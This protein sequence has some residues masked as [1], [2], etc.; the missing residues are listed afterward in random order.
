[1][2][3]IPAAGTRCPAGAIV[4]LVVAGRA[5]GTGGQALCPDFSGLSNRQARG[6]AARLGIPLRIAGAGYVAAQMPRP[7]MALGGATVSLR[8]ESPWR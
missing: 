3:Q 4:R 1:V 7:G 5:D 8:M 2:T 6:L